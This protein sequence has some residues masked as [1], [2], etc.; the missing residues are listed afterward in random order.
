MDRL[1]GKRSARRAQNTKI[2]QEARLLLDSADVEIAKLSAVKERLAA[3]NDQLSQIDE[4]YE[5]YIPTENIE[6]EYTAIAEYQDEAAGILAELQCRISQMERDRNGHAQ[7]PS[8]EST[9]EPAFRNEAPA[10]FMAPRLPQL[11]IPTFRGDIAQ[12][13]GFWEQ[14]EQVVHLNN[15][16]TPSTKF[17]YLKSFLAGDAAAAIAGLPTTESCYAGTVAMLKERFGDKTSIIQHHLTA[18]RNLPNVTSANDIRGFQRLYDATQLNIRCLGALNV[19]T[20]TY[21]AMLVDILQ[22]A[23]PRDISLSFTRGKRYRALTQSSDVRAAQVSSSGSPADASSDSD[24]ELNDLFAVHA[25][26]ARKQRTAR[27]ATSEA[28]FGRSL[29]PEA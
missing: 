14:F 11:H 8:G 2:I 28:S 5:Q 15:D 20:L 23:L 26:G 12:W 17:Y 7:A 21:S 1:K 10:R 16:L 29:G 6:Q 9:E 25:G 24:A 22:Q 18:L 27:T 3:S 13:T 19:P 4:L